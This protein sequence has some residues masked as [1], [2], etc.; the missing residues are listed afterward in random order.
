MTL[1]RGYEKVRGALHRTAHGLATGPKQLH[2]PK[3]RGAPLDHPASVPAPTA[4][5][6]PA[7]LVIRGARLLEDPDRPVTLAI[8]GGVLSFVGDDDGAGAFV[9]PDTE[10]LDAGGHTVLP[11]LC[12]AHVHLLVG[13]ERL[14]GC[15]VEE[16]RDPEALKD[17]LRRY[18]EDH[19]DKEVLHVYGVHYTDPPLI[20]ARTARQFLD[21]IETERP[22]FV[23]AHDLHTAWANTR[24]L[25]MAGLRGPVPPYPEL[26]EVLDLK[27]NLILGDDGAPSGE[28][29]EPPVYFLVEGVLHHHFPLTAE[30]KL[31]YLEETCA[32]LAEFGITRVHNMGLGSPEEDI[33]ILLLLL[34]LEQQGRLP[35]R[36]FSS[37]SVLPDE[38]MLTDVEEAAAAARALVDGRREGRT[39]G[40]VH[41]LLLDQLEQ[42]SGKRD[43][44]MA[45][46][47]GQKPGLKDHRHAGALAEHAKQVHAL[48]Y[49][50]HVAP[51][52]QRRQAR[53]AAGHAD[54]LPATGRVWIQAV[55]AF[56]DGVVEKHTAYRLDET[57]GEGI[58][59]FSQD[60]IDQVVAAADR[61]GLQVAAHSIGDG[62]VH[63]ML[64]AIA[65]ARKANA[66][67]TGKRGRAVRHRIEHI[68]LCDP[69]DLPRFR[70][71][72][73]V[74]SMQPFHEREP[75][76][77]WHQTVPKD[78]WDRAFLWQTLLGTGVPLVLGSDWPIVSCD[79]LR[80]AQ[81]AVDRKPWAEGMKDQS[82][83]VK[84]ALDGFSAS[85]AVVE[86]LEDRLGRVE[87]GMMADLVIL[88]GCLDGRRD[89]AAPGDLHAQVT[90]CD[91]EVTFRR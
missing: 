8:T 61:A 4:A 49:Q 20:P 13:A 47:T 45:Q 68:E 27:E 83:S 9:G 85:T 7:D 55:K 40:E 62:A 69:A 14:Q 54:T 86:H 63:A 38:H 29:R 84:Q 19:P 33:E 77:L 10:T 90:I 46:M 70:E 79:C 22:L 2:Q 50:T 64:D 39:Y 57:P 32:S 80:A 44:S 65:A 53:V 24:A 30:E 76:T 42:V 88:D 66:D 67:A 51:H 25:Q 75:V 17:R 34:E 48:A 81:H 26:L 36:V 56:M 6:G 87:A 31:D 91:G 21:E 58:P 43:D 11:G 71:L 89:D 1:I 28:L 15:D 18:A 35:L 73:V 41:A 72:E 82:L 52:Q 60:E 23:Y 59:A 16:V 74:P 37:Y 12:D 78:R 5:P 3:H